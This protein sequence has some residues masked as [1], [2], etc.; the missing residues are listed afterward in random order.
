MNNGEGSIINAPQKQHLSNSP[1]IKKNHF[2]EVI[3]YYGL[4]C[5]T[6]L[7]AIPYGTVEPWFKLLFVFL[8]SVFVIFRVLEAILNRSN[9]F[10]NKVFFAPLIGIIVVAIIQINPL[11]ELNGIFSPSPSFQ[12]PISLNIYETKNFIIIFFG[13]LILAETLLHYTNS[14][15][16]IRHLIYLVFIISMSTTL[17]GFARILL[18]D[19]GNNFLSPYLTEK[20]QFAQFVNRNHYAYLMEMNVGLL[21]GLQLKA[22]LPQWQKP[23][24]WIMTALSCFSIIWVNSR[25]AILSLVGMSIFAVL[26][27]FFS[28]ENED[29]YFEFDNKPQRSRRGNFLKPLLATVL[30][31]TLIL[32]FAVFIISFV[33]SDPV[34]TRLES[35]QE[36]IAADKSGKTSR[37]E[38]WSATIE[39]IKDH[40]VFGVGFGAYPN[41]I[42]TYD[43]SAGELALQQA[44]NDYL[45]IL[46]NGGVV[47]FILLAVFIVFLIQRIKVQIKANSRFRR[48][49]C[50]GATLGIFGIMLHSLVDF[51]LHIIINTFVLTILIVIATANINSKNR[52]NDR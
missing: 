15:K 29:D 7:S 27:Y 11:R 8:T 21:V 18:L 47:A 52:L 31:S 28:K 33:G 3:A 35:I 42:T 44:H 51:G 48:A 39:L 14:E 34:V 12:N 23:F 19:S 1:L 9:I 50:F 17:L 4:L 40:P 37:K 5:V 36:E 41:A 38:I 25:G 20:I 22:R 45:E 6:F 2:F 32:G 49:S 26:L 24:Y 10:S 30:F 13:L 43:K 46:A 16:K